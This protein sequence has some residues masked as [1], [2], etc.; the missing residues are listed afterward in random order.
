M[1]STDR[2][3]RIGLVLGAGGIAGHAFE[4]GVLAA[5]AERTRWNPQQ[6]EVIVGTSA[7]SLVGALVRAGVPAADLAARITG[8]PLTAEGRH[9]FGGL[10]PPRSV[11]GPARGFGM[12]APEMLIR[13]AARPWDAR[14]GTVASA[15]LPAGRVVNHS[16]EGLGS[17]Y[18]ERDWPSGSLWICAVRLRDGRRVVF[19][20]DGA[21]PCHVA[22]AVS[23][24]CAVP[25]WFE[26][27]VI[28]G[29]R[30]VDGGAHSPSNLDILAGRGLDLVVVVSPM[31]LEPSV[32][33]ASADTMLRRAVGLRL[34]QERRQVQ[35]RGTPVVVIE[36][37]QRDLDAMGRLSGAMDPARPAD[38]ARRSRETTRARLD[39]TAMREALAPMFG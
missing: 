34:A 31:T 24:S 39:V 14:T 15:V 3:P 18:G 13:L 6:A 4:S 16:L 22:D 26:P 10:E 2:A 11:Q 5:I 8:D 7:G 25:G 20:R 12:A 28:A 33:G 30:H 21:P 9:L 27:V 35:A 36:P 32:R 23:A 38:V 37:G 1:S 19:G 17:L 29:E